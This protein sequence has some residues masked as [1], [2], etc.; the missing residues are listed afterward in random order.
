[1][2]HEA[3]YSRLGAFLDGELGAE[4][5][6]AV[7]A[8][9]ISCGACAAEAE[10]LRAVGRGLRTLRAASMGAEAMAE[11]HERVEFS[12]QRR[13]V[14]WFAG[15]LSAVAACVAIVMGIQMMRATEQ[16]AIASPASWES[17]AVRLDAGAEDT[18][19]ADTRQ[20]TMA[21][22]MVAD[23]SSEEKPRE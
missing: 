7:E 10:R 1:M 2:G 3:I 20:A 23:L 19:V 9:L 5:K 16:T 12:G 6:G 14:E 18:P 17:A 15:G 21:Q 22:F 11:L 13:R 4:E 8:H